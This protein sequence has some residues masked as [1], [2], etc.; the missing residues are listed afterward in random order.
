MRHFLRPTVALLFAALALLTHRA[1]PA[2]HA[3]VITTTS[4][5]GAA[6]QAVG[7]DS[8]SVETILPPGSCPGHFDLEPA[9]VRRLLACELFLRHDFQS[10]LDGRLLANGVARDRIAALPAAGGLCVPD[11]FVALGRAAAEALAVRLPGETEALRT[12]AEALAHEAQ[13]RGNTL[14]ART[15]RLRGKPVAGALHQAAFLR[16]LGLDVR[17][18]LPGGDDPTPGAVSRAL[19]EIR[20]TGALAI[21]G[22]VP[23]GRRLPSTLASRGPPLVMF[24]NF[25]PSPRACRLLGHA[26]PQRRPP[27]RRA[28]RI[29]PCRTRSSP[30]PT[31]PSATPAGHCW[32]T[33]RLRSHAAVS[34][35]CSAPTAPVRPHCCACSTANSHPPPAPAVSSAPIRPHSTGAAARRGVAESA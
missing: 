13:T 31:S 2:E 22:N 32:T 35:P 21:V 9:Q 28:P 19:T 5:L 29:A 16:W 3:V 23:S 27:A 33:S 12:R 34:P 14:L 7:G 8:V 25:P 4:T 1:H 20:A 11:T 17:C 10:F 30:S 18:V 6:A 24:D 15:A 26:R